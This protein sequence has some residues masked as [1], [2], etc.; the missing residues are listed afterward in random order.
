MKKDLLI[1]GLIFTLIIQTCILFRDNT[2]NEKLHR[3]LETSQT[4][5][6]S[7]KKYIEALEESRTSLNNYA[8]ELENKI[9]RIEKMDRVIKDLSQHN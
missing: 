6:N 8:N 4:E 5:I 1:I 9:T 3:K 7:N 2:Q